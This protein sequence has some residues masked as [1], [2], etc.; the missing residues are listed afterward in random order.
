MLGE[1][2]VE[3]SLLVLLTRFEPNPLPRQERPDHAVRWHEMAGWLQET[4]Q[5]LEQG[6]SKYFLC[7]Q[8]LEFL[9][10]RGL[11]MEQVGWELLPGIQALSNFIGILD[12]A[13]KGLGM[14]IARGGAGSKGVGRGFHTPRRH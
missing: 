5:G 6:T 3:Q 11:T 9:R 1:R 12:E 10:G 7:Q 13:I 14:N 4:A 8:F 2:R